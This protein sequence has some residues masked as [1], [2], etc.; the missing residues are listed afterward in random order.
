MKALNS[1][2]A[3]SKDWEVVRVKPTK[4]LG[5]FF[6]GFIHLCGKKRKTFFR[7]YRI[8]RPDHDV[9]PKLF[10]SQFKTPFHSESGN[11]FSHLILFSI[12][13]FCYILH[14]S[15]FILGLYI[16]TVCIYIYICKTEYQFKSLSVMARGK[17]LTL[18]LVVLP[19][20][21]LKRHL[22]GR[23]LKRLSSGMWGFCR[24]STCT[25]PDPPWPVQVLNE[26]RLEPIILSADLMV[27][28]IP[29]MSC[30]V[31]DLN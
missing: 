9:K 27:L 21:V 1:I 25:L 24:D 5:F 16:H 7:F 11:I 14:L 22:E 15:A 29:S 3:F 18:W 30:L 6:K 19:Y 10:K 13:I 12:H 17:K 8:Y 23:R 28:Y 2:W 4:E 31:A 26:R 20:K